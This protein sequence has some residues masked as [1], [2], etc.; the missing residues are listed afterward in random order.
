MFDEA[1]EEMQEA[2]MNGMLIDNILCANDTSIYPDTIDT[3][4]SFDELDKRV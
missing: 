4:S 3:S 2:R 1:L